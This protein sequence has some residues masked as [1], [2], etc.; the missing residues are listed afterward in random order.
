MKVE[1]SQVGILSE[2]VFSDN[3]NIIKVSCK[4]EHES[5]N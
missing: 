4:S 5:A 2:L 3:D 1:I